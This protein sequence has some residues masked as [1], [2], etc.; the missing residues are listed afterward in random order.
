[1]QHRRPRAD[2]MF[3]LASSRD[4]EDNTCPWTRT[5]LPTPTVTIID[6]TLYYVPYFGD[7]SVCIG[8]RNS[9]L[10]YLGC[11]QPTGN[12]WPN[13][14][15]IRPKQWVPSGPSNCVRYHESYHRFSLYNI[16]YY[17]RGPAITYCGSIS[18]SHGLEV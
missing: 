9:S 17:T 7:V 3:L 10:L 14:S 12:L 4:A 8:D 15:G 16:N 1:M 18:H 6:N 11:V 2:I 13:S 5:W